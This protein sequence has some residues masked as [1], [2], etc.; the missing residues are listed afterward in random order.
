MDIAVPCKT[1]RCFPNNKPWITRDIKELLNKKKRAFRDGDR[2]ELKRVQGELK[3]RLKE[4]KESY[5]R[6]IE[7]KL[8][9]NNMREVWNGMKTITGC[10]KK[11]RNSAEGD[12]VF[13]PQN[14]STPKNK[15]ED[16]VDAMGHSSSTISAGQ[17]LIS[18]SE[19]NLDPP[20][21]NQ[22]KSL[23]YSKYTDLYAPCVEDEEDEEPVPVNVQNIPDL[24]M[25]EVNITL[26]EI[27]TNLSHPIDH[28]RVS[29]F[30]ISRSNVWDGAIRGFKRATYSETCD[31]LVRFTDDAGV[32]EDGIDAGGP[33]REFLTLLMKHLKDRPIFDGPAGQ[34]FLVYN[35]ND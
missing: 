12:V 4:A 28:G 25:E 7:Q 20:G 2:E 33:R 31:M 23:C 22:A 17:I 18:D 15:P 10:K 5:R 35:A 32:F 27:I 19:D 26:P 13:K 34:R 1:V 24:T 6:K 3:V 11:G 29:R 8:Q 9:E 30:N 14:Q 16:E 21:S